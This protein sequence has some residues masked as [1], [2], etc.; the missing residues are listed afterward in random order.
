M[1]A[2]EKAIL[3]GYPLQEKPQITAD[4]GDYLTKINK[5]ALSKLA[6]FYFET[7]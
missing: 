6:L 1:P 4:K 2:S 3:M 5:T 7:S